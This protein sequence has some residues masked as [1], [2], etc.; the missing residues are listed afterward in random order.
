VPAAEVAALVSL[1]DVTARTPARGQLPAWA[2]SH[3]DHA[4]SHLGGLSCAWNDEQDPRLG[5]RYAEG[6][7]G[8][9]VR[10]LPA[11]EAAWQ[12]SMAFH[13]GTPPPNCREETAGYRC[14]ADGSVDTTWI[15]V[16]FGGLD[17]STEGEAQ[18]AAQHLLDRVAERV[19]AAG[20]Q[21]STWTPP[22]DSVV[23][24]G[25]C[26]QLLTS[27]QVAEISGA[28]DVGFETPHG[29]WSLDAASWQMLNAMP[30]V[31]STA[32]TVDQTDMPRIGWL[33]AGEWAWEATPPTGEPVTLTTAQGT[34]AAVT[35]CAEDSC[36]LDL[37]VASN[38]VTVVISKEPEA[39]FD[40]DRA[41]AH[42]AAYTEAITG[43]VRG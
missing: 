40:A 26:E 13:D 6:W 35:R 42:L 30:C 25:S 14:D 33:P 36:E 43:N 20:P 16:S 23:V 24:A 18:A 19:T 38:W 12:R 7:V 10:V 4:V 39:A 28:E 31:F 2:G 3:F 37:L 29:G 22:T 41:V 17:A 1:D 27:A 5:D 9:D 32:A 21:T 34:D 8:L 11:S 15:Q